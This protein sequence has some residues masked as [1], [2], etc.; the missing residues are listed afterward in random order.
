MI[1][2][3]TTW[4]EQV[5]NN[6]YVT[7]GTK[8]SRPKSTAAARRQPEDEPVDDAAKFRTEDELEV[9]QTAE[10]PLELTPSPPQAEPDEVLPSSSI[11]N[12]HTGTA[13]PEQGAANVKGK[14][15]SG[16]DS[17][18]SEPV[19]YFSSEFILAT[20]GHDE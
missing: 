16:E 15:I 20:L 5:Q 3:G 11:A 4:A 18:E 14:T 2:K 10:K 12:S 7:V 1:L 8:A 6:Q 19:D 9:Q 17:S 13:A